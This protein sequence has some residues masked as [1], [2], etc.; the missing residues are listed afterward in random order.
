MLK[1]YRPCQHSLCW[2][3]KC[4]N[5]PK[6]S[7]VLNVITFG[8]KHNTALNVITFSLTCNK[9]PMQSFNC[10]NIE[11]TRKR[12]STDLYIRQI[13]GSEV[14]F[15]YCLPFAR[16]VYKIYSYALLTKSEVKMVGYWLSSF[17]CIMDLTEQ[18]WSR[19]FVFSW[20]NH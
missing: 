4:N 6:C 2:S 12:K 11:I 17:Y 7:K 15:L 14:H 3:P 1:G 18:A 20:R 10:T 13:L 9:P 5:C 19:E 16:F 8:P